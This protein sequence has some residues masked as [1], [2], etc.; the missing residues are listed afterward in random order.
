[1]I[2]IAVFE[3][4]EENTADNESLKAYSHAGWEFKVEF[5]WRYVFGTK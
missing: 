5:V 3:M 4:K 2:V 1:M